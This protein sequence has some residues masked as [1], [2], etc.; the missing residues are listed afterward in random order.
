MIHLN[1]WLYQ[2]QSSGLGNITW[3]MLT[4]SPI[5][6]KILPPGVALM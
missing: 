4:D 1:D 2:V 3:L 6:K 5:F